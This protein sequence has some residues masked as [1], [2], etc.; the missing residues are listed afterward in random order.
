MVSRTA[1][2]EHAPGRASCVSTLPSLALLAPQKIH[3]SPVHPAGVKKRQAA[4]AASAKDSRR[5]QE[6]AK[7]D[8]PPCRYLVSNTPYPLQGTGATTCSVAGNARRL[9]TRPVGYPQRYSFISSHLL[10][11][12]VLVGDVR[13]KTPCY[14]FPPFPRPKFRLGRN[15]VA[16]DFCLFIDVANRVIGTVLWESAWIPTPV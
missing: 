16:T 3:T 10:V 14:R 6:I 13:E 4:G 7:G 9:R 8:S 2:G 11:H 5:P 12:P 15:P 1:P